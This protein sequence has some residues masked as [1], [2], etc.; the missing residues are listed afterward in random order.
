M[1]VLI[2]CE[3]SGTVREAFRKLGHDAWSCDVLPADDGS[4]YHIQ[5]DVLDVIEWVYDYTRAAILPKEK[6][7]KSYWDLLIIHPPCTYLTCSA[8]WAYS[9]G[10]YHQQVQPGTL[11]GLARRIARDA[12]LEFV[13]KILE[14]PIPKIALENPVGVISTRLRPAD[15]YIQPYEFGDNASKKTGLWLKNLPKLKPTEYCEPRIVNGKKRW[16]NQTDSG[17]NKLGPSADRWKVRSKTFPGIADAM[18]EQW[19]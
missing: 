4:E 18:A 19:G 7:G 1:K 16:D 14:C 2:G 11:V 6:I 10:P 8:E 17:Q 9:D 12:A 5:A 3:S 13:R 15:Q